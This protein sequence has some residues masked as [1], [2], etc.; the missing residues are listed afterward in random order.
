MHCRRVIHGGASSLS[1]CSLRSSST[2]PMRQGLVSAGKRY[3]P[4]TYC[5]EEHYHV[6]FFTNPEAAAKGREGSPWH[7]SMRPGATP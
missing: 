5:G 4:R 3:V 2:L 7:D 6:L 1:S